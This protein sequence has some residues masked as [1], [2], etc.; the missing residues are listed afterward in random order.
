[1]MVTIFIVDNMSVM[2]LI[3]TQDFDGIV[4]TP[5]SQKLVVFQKG[6]KLEKSQTNK[7]KE[8]YVRL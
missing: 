8:S 5:I 7:K 1:M 2:F 4:M 6:F 3:S